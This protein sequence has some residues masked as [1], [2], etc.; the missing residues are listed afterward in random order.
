MPPSVGWPMSRS[1]PSRTAVLA[2]AGVAVGLLVVGGSSLGFV[3]VIGGLFTPAS[4]AVDPVVPGTWS[5]YGVAPSA[6]SGPILDVV[7][8]WVVPNVT[9]PAANT[10]NAANPYGLASEAIGV[11][12]DHYGGLGALKMDGAGVVIACV[13]GTA[14]YRAWVQQAPLPAMLLPFVVKPGDNVQAN[15][16]LLGWAIT[17]FTTPGG[18]AGSW[19]T[20]VST[21]LAHNSAECVVSR[22]PA[23]G[24]LPPTFRPVPATVPNALTNPVE[25]GS[26]YAKAPSGGPLEG[27]WY[28][29]ILVT[30]APGPV[31]GI[32]NVAAPLVALTFDL[33]N[34]SAANVIAPGPLATGT[35]LDD[36]FVVP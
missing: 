34:P 6:K 19:T 16:T 4:S 20:A 7:G 18:A 3:S 31:L 2:L 8:S 32:G 14:V 5:G 12:L 33:L 24:V 15:V 22:T 21:K 13:L 29:S 17:D 35:L 26:L 27:C 10:T 11:G 25:F 28:Q 9:C 30:G 36:S 23:L 1:A